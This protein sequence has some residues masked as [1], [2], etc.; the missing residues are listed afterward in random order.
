MSRIVVLGAGSW[1][2]TIAKVIADGGTE[3]ALWARRPQQAE[4]IQATKLNQEYL[5]DIKL[6][7]LILPTS[8]IESAL[9]DAEQIYLAVPSPRYQVARFNTANIKHR[10]STSRCR[11]DLPGSAIPAASS[12]SD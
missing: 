8:N 7:D 10:V 11:A 9:L 1:G 2:T 6:P 3:V 12:E 5:P 4:E